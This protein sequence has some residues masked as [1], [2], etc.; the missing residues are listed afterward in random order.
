MK[1]KGV[2]ESRQTL[3]SHKNSHRKSGPNGKSDKGKDETDASVSVLL[4]NGEDQ[5]EDSLPKY[6]RKLLEE[7]IE[8][9]IQRTR[10]SKR[11]SP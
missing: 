9:S 1:S 2:K 8:N 3:H 11:K 4:G 6:N 5:K 10:V 7:L